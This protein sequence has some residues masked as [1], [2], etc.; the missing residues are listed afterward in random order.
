MYTN[1]AGQNK[2]VWS[3]SSFGQYLT[4]GAEAGFIL[5]EGKKVWDYIVANVS[6]ARLQTRAF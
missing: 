3:W 2:S 1:A 4:H 6:S 5:D